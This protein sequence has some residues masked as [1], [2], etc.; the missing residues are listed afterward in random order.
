MFLG[1][2]DPVCHFA[3]GYRDRGNR[4]NGREGGGRPG[5]VS[6]FDRS[7]CTIHGV[8]ELAATII[9]AEISTDMGHFPTAGDLLARAR[10]CPG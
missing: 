7:L 9:L 6:P 4:A 10:L 5:P 1:A 8:G 3:P 2:E